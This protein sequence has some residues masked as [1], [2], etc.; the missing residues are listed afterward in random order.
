MTEE[1][2]NQC[3]TAT[4]PVGSLQTNS[5]GANVARWNPAAADPVIFVSSLLGPQ[6]VPDHG[7]VPICFPWFGPHPDTDGR[8]AEVPF[9]GATAFQG[10]HG[11]VRDAAWQLMEQSTSQT[12]AHAKYQL[13][14]D[15]L[16]A[17][18]AA[19][20]QP[21]R[22]NYSVHASEDILE[23]QLVV[24]N[25]SEAAFQFEE[26]LHTY[27]RVSSLDKVRIEGLEGTPFF[28]KNNPEDSPFVEARPL[29]I[30][31]PTD[32][33]YQSE[34]PVTLADRGF[35]RQ[36]DVAKTGSGTTVVWNPGEEGGEALADLGPGD[37]ERFVCIET[38]N[39]WGNAIVLEPGESHVMTARYRV[40]SV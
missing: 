28:D 33:V 23:L 32:N 1:P 25:L 12:S 18:A 13:S 38:A 15:D 3:L 29:R 9:L 7:G 6:E 2:A 37:W 36:I 35:S 27:F 20:V 24:T 16:D 19:L 39:V 34:A 10:A 8:G 4:T 17:E 26:A 11:F 22:A 40:R 14:N 5:H 21:F 30:R 31:R